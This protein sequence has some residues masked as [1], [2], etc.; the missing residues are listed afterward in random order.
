MKKILTILFCLIA[1]TNYAQQNTTSK[2]NQKTTCK[3][4][5]VTSIRDISRTFYYSDGKEIE[6]GDA[7]A[8]SIVTW[9]LNDAL[10]NDNLTFYEY[11]GGKKISKEEA[12][13]RLKKT[14]AISGLTPKDIVAIQYVESVTFDKTKPEIVKTVHMFGPVIKVLNNEGREIGKE[15][16]F[17]IKLN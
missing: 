8:D 14:T 13:A 6:E 9:M 11:F 2:G 7:F 3:E 16:L 10:N 15:T 1:L 5:S 4:D 17:L 12:K